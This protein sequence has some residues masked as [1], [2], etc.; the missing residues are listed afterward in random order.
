MAASTGA[1]LNP[2]SHPWTLL[3]AQIILTSL[4]VGF[5]KPS[6]FIRPAMLLPI[7][8]MTTV[9]ISTARTR[10]DNIFQLSWGGSQA[11]LATYQYIDVAI[12]SRWNFEHSGPEPRNKSEKQRSP[13]GADNP[14]NRLKFGLYAASSFRNCATVF[15]TRGIK[16]FNRKDPSF[17][18]SKERFIV[19]AT[20][21]LIACYLTLDALTSLG[22]PDKQA[23]LFSESRIP[24]LSRLDQVTMQELIERL[25]CS[26]VFWIVNYLVL[27]TSV[28][29]ISLIMVGTGLSSVA[30]WKPLFNIDNGFPYTVRRFW[31]NFWHLSVRNRIFAP[32][33]YTVHNIL[34]LPRGS[35]NSRYMVLILTFAYSAGFHALGDISCGISPHKTG[36]W[37]F[38]SVQAVAVMVEDLVQCMWKQIFPETKSQRQIAPWQ[39]WVGRLWV[40]L[41]MYW[42]T[43]FYAYPVTAHNGDGLI[44]PFSVIRRMSVW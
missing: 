11:V 23:V 29:A 26:L 32:S 35:A 1:S 21:H 38:F 5:T 6:C 34:K 44:V 9:Y 15:E 27:S 33:V 10:V 40:F 16:P 14:W 17:I 12:V 24:L 4:T 42:C 2:L 22:D 43:P 30:W 25:T 7:L 20:M 39:I 18:P 37:L 8:C 19:S 31:S 36:A 13:F 3:A 28:T 41:L